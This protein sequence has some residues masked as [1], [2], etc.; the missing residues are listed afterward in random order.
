MSFPFLTRLALFLGGFGFLF[1]LFVCA[2]VSPATSELVGAE[3]GSYSVTGKVPEGPSGHCHPIV[4]D[5]QN[6]F[7]REVDLD[8]APL[9]EGVDYTVVDAGSNKGI[10]FFLVDLVPGDVIEVSGPT[11]EPGPHTG[12]LTFF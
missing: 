4:R 9:M 3:T 8:G 5:S 10:I 1:T 11:L 6:W 7:V 2:A 12:V